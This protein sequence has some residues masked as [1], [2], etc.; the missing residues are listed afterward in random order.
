MS[1]IELSASPR[2]ESGK[3]PARRTRRE[4]K[5][6]AVIYGMG[7]D[8]VN[9]ILD[10]EE[11]GDFIS[12]YNYLTSL[13]KLKV[14]GRGDLDSRVF[15]IQE[16]QR[17]HIERAPMAVDFKA[18]DVDKPIVVTVAV[19]YEGTAAGVK[20]GAI[21]QRLARD[22]QLVCI[23]TAIPQMIT[24]DV[25]ELKDSETWYAEHL[26]LPEGVTLS[27]PPDTPIVTCIKPRKEEEVKPG[28]EGEGEAAEGGESAEGGDEKKPE[29]DG[30]DK[31]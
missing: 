15:M 10:A 30:E 8:P 4:G 31:G 21:M 16:L 7:L 20:K 29:A 23:P 18:I 11:F 22:I 2:T 17:H 28:E 24:V 25:T 3:G 27:S 5:I 6:P 19:K 12:N 9:V 13:I 26:A 14:E 1:M